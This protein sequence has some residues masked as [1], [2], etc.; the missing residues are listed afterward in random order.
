MKKK[1]SLVLLSLIMLVNLTTINVQAGNYVVEEKNPNGIGDINII[2]TPNITVE[3]AQ[4]WARRVTNGRATEAF[5]S[6]APLYKKYSESRG[7]INWAIAYVQA[8]KETGYGQF[9]GVLTEEYYNPC[10]LKNPIGGNDYDPN[11]HKK[12][13][14]WDQGVIAHLDHLAL[15]AGSAGYPKAI[16]V[17]RY[18]DAA[19]GE[20][21]TYD[22]RH[23][24]GWY[25]SLYGTAP[26]INSLGGNQKWNSNIIYG[27]DLFRMYCQLTNTKYVEAKSN[28][29]T[30]KEDQVIEGNN[31]FIKGWALHAFGIKEVKVL[32]DGEKLEDPEVGMLRADVNREYP[33]Y[34]NSINSGFEKTYDISNMS[35]GKKV[36][37]DRKSVV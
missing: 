2:S 10:G 5:I 33:E 11:A 1:I 31:L 27:V 14:N 22:P 6:L 19:L 29:E 17:D 26:T 32:L 20:N 13:D 37:T 9:G 4:D 23:S 15:Y 36:L 28:L 35:K 7:K 25:P 16:Y 3:Q 21:E 30:I 8:A 18:K 12:F 34:F 24:T